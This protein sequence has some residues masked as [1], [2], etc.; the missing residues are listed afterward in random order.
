MPEN[1]QKS[2]RLRDYENPQFYPFSTLPIEDA[3]RTLQLRALQQLIKS[4]NID[5]GAKPKD[6]A[7]RCKMFERKYEEHFEPD[8]FK[9]VY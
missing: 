5:E 7:T 4:T 8:V 1:P 2:K 6:R 3:E 9:Q